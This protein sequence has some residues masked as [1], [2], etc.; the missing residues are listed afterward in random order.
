VPGYDNKVCGQSRSGFQTFTLPS[1]LARRTA[2]RH[3]SVPASKIVTIK[4]S[5]KL[6]R[7]IGM[8]THNVR[9]G[10]IY[11]AAARGGYS[12]KP[13]PVVVIQDDRFDATASVTVVPFTTSDVE[14]PLLRI[15]VRPS[16]STGLTQF[17]RLMVDKVT[18]VSRASLGDFIGRLSDAEIIQLNR[19]L[20]VFL[21]LAA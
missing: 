7:P 14:A 8:T 16:E 6:C 13:R 17:S 1:S 2:S 21:G 3:S 15:P 4:P 20:V 9:R 18:T 11:T 19:A 12:G 10:D 5:S